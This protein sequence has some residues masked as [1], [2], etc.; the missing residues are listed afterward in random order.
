MTRKQKRDGKSSSTDPSYR[1]ELNMNV[2]TGIN[3]F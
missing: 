1:V 3:N 2:I